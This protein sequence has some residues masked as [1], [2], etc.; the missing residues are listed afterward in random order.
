MLEIKSEKQQEVLVVRLIGRLDGLT[1][2]SFLEHHSAPEYTNCARVVLNCVELNYISS[3]GLRVILMAAKQAKA[4]GGSL[5]LC[6][7]N[8]SVGEVMAISGF[9]QLLGVHA[10]LEQAIQA[11]Q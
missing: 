5:T 9:D 7:V 6:E 1:A 11:I 4:L 2:K 10:S 8:A 3:E